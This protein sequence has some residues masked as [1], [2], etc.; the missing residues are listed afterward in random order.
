M[1]A[2]TP[3]PPAATETLLLRHPAISARHLAFV[4]AGDLWIADLD[5]RNAR[6]LTVPGG[7][8]VAP[9]FSPDGQFLAYSN[10]GAGSMDVYVVPVA[11][12]RPRR[13]TFH[14]GADLV[15]GWTPD[16]RVLFASS[17]ASMNGRVE[18]LYTLAPD[19]G[20]PEVLPR[21]CCLNRVGVG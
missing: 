1:T 10:S 14:P 8:T 11:G 4:Y 21:L 2:D 20:H 3:A 9:S 6:R 15:R 7:S 19:A 13:L 16:G 17:R 12:G 18:Q 5:G